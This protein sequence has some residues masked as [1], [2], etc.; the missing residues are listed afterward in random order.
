VEESEGPRIR[1]KGCI[2]N[3]RKVPLASF[4]I[5]VGSR[6]TAQLNRCA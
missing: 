5:D 3:K 6:P 2:R 1:C 4:R